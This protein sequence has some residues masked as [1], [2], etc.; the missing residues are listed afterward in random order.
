MKN[1]SHRWYFYHIC[2]QLLYFCTSKYNF[3]QICTISGIHRTINRCFCNPF[4]VY[5]GGG[6]YSL[7]M[8]IGGHIFY[9]T[10]SCKLF[11]S[12]IVFSFCF[13][14]PCC[15]KAMGYIREIKKDHYHTP[16]NARMIFNLMNMKIM[17]FVW[18]MTATSRQFQQ[19]PPT[20]YHVF[21]MGFQM[22]RRP[23]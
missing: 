15:N 6:C 13:R 17:G 10:S 20:T 19:P 11:P 14:R 12:R 3:M 21:T 1:L 5:G 16:K 22:R 18:V 8:E 9:S 7:V 2:S 4:W 23:K